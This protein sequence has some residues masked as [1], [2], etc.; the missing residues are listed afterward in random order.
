MN[1]EREGERKGD[2]E[3]KESR[4]DSCRSSHVGEGKVI[5]EMTSGTE[6]LMVE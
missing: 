1:K 4:V 3:K 6:C 5:C 2:L